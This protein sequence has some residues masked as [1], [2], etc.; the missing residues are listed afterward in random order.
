M[1]A[2]RASAVHEKGISEMATD[3]TQGR[4]RKSVVSDSGGCVE[5]ARVG[6]VIGVRD[7]KAQGNGPVLEFT[8]HEW[9]AFLEGVANG[10]FTLGALK[11]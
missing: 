4:W 5:V 7:T 8:P 2:R 9:S 1:S 3:W 11:E 6:D 10:E